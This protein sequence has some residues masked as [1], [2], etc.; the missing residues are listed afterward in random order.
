MTVITAGAVV[1]RVES[2]LRQ[3]QRCGDLHLAV[4]DVTH[5]EPGVYMVNRINTPALWRG[6]G[7]ASA[8]LKACCREADRL[9]I[10]LIL[11][12]NPSDGLGYKDL[13]AWY[14]RHGF[15]ARPSDDGYFE[16]APR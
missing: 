10:T 12:I 11:S 16:R 9:G 13:L 4:L 3:N 1:A 7:I 6:K 5:V 8:M 15:V 14:G 2:V